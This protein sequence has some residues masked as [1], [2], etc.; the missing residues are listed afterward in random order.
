MAMGLPNNPEGE[1]QSMSKKDTDSSDDLAFAV[2][3]PAGTG[4]HRQVDEALVANPKSTR[5]VGDSNDANHSKDLVQNAAI[6]EPEIATVKHSTSE[7]D[8]CTRAV[9]QVEESVAVRPMLKDQVRSV[10]HAYDD[11]GADITMNIT[12][13][14]VNGRSFSA[15]LAQVIPLDGGLDPG[16][17]TLHVEFAEAQLAPATTSGLAAIESTGFGPVLFWSLPWLSFLRLW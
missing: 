3:P 7:Q 8:S 5:E 17:P 9:K 11:R 14:N 13:S 2:T 4:S 6:P 16:L 15:P 1:Q 10:Q 12:S